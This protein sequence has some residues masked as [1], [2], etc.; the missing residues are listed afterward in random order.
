MS[1]VCGQPLAQPRRDANPAGTWRGGSAPATAWRDTNRAKTRRR[2]RDCRDVSAPR[3]YYRP[4]PGLG[5]AADQTSKSSRGA[6]QE[7]R[8]PKWT[9]VPRQSRHHVVHRP[10]F[11]SKALS[12]SVSCIANAS[13]VWIIFGKSP[14]AGA[15]VDERTTLWALAFPHLTCRLH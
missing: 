2:D 5:V 1:A 4:S 9:T 10:I 3:R 15:R 7:V 14:R 13:A 12:L 6:D 11:S 8:Q